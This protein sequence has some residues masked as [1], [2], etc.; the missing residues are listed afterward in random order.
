[1]L[2]A[3]RPLDGPG[4][5]DDE[6]AREDLLQHD[7]D[8]RAREAGAEAV[9]DTV[10]EREVRVRI[11]RDVE[12]E[13][14]REDALVAIR[15]RVPVRD[16]VAGADRLA[17]Q[18]HVARRGAAVVGGGARPA[19]DLFDGT[20]HEPPVG[21]QRAHLLRMLRERE[22]TAGDRVARGLGA[23]DEQQRQEGDDLVV[24]QAARGSGRVGDLG[25]HDEREHVVA[26]LRAFVSDERAPV[27]G[28]ADRRVAQP[29]RGLP[30]LAVAV[31]H[32]RRGPREDLV[33]IGLGHA[34]EARGDLQRQLG[35]DVAQ[36]VAP[37]LRYDGVEDRARCVRADRHRA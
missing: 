25:V 30:E 2:V 19:Q 6:I 35:G 15:G 33:A 4:R 8:L 27:A 24:R 32:E 16:L 23:G 14:I 11:A 3:P 26:R 29:L 36:E 18:R 22:H 31:V 12:A 34:E 28:D 13:R 1:V 37:A 21:A 5:L 10:A 9:V 7:R 17:G 20:G